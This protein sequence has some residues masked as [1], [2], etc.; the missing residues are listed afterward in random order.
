MNNKE[1]KDHIPDRH[2]LEFEGLIDAL[3]QC[4][5]ERMQYQSER[6]GLPDA[7]LRCLLQFQNERYLTAKALAGRLNVA[8]SRVTKIVDGLL[9]RKLVERTDDPEDC[10]VKLLKLTAGGDGLAREILSFRR[11]MHQ[12]V[13]NQFSLEQRVWLL[14]GLSQLKRSLES[15]RELL[16]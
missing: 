7:E 5:Q 11:E 8:K 10:R 6:F 1:R 9:R 16:V 4:C 2:V 13:L 12:G 3:F 15:V 14:N